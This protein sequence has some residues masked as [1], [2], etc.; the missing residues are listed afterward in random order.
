MG[1]LIWCD[2]PSV[3]GHDVKPQLTC[4]LV[5]LTW[6]TVTGHDVKPQLTCCLVWLTWP[7]VTGHDVK[8]Q[9]T[10]CLVWLT[11]PTVTGHDVKP[12]LTCCC[13]QVLLLDK[14]KQLG[15]CEMVS[16]MHIGLS[17]Q[18]LCRVWSIVAGYSVS[19]WP[20][21]RH[22]PLLQIGPCWSDTRLRHGPLQICGLVAE[23]WHERWCE[24]LFIRLD[25]DAKKSTT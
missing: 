17:V 6:P 5:W 16:L 21:V 13:R 20:C 7:T 23:P 3:T 8:P 12:Q 9:L 22:G 1:V 19:A 25:H 2:W 18:A 24:H 14:M 15:L 11:W 4:C 10:C